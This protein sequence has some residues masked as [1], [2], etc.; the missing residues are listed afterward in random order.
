M[1][2]IFPTAEFTTMEFR[3]NNNVKS[4]ISVS[5]RTQRVK[6]GGQFWSFTLESPALTKTDFFSQYSFIVKQ[7]GQAESFT[8]VPPEI[9]S[10]KGTASGIFTIT[11]NASAG[12]SR[13]SGDGALGTLLKGDLIKFSNHD[14]VYMLTEN[15]NMDSSSEDFLHIFPSLITSVTAS[16][17]T[18]TYND[19]PFTVFFDGNE[20]G[21]TTSADGTYKYRIACQE[22][23]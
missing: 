8:I 4:T 2:G 15:V 23:I 20:L 17:T 16:T 9:A 13:V 10:T 19:V 1:S 11:K 12:S 6:A 3:S 7:N 21:F 18:V 14:K 22:E 5:G